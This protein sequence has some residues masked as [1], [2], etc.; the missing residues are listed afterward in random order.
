MARVPKALVFP[1]SAL[2]LLASVVLA[3]VIG[4]VDIPVLYILKALISPLPWVGPMVGAPPDWVSTVVW[5]LRLP[6][7]AMA[8]FVGVGLSVSGASMQG[9]FR[10]PLV[11]PFIL[12][13]SAGGAFGWV[14]ALTLTQGLGGLPT[15]A[16]RAFFSFVFSV[17]AVILA[18]TIA[19]SGGR[20]PLNNLLLAGIAVSASLTSL[21]QVL[22][23]L[24]SETPS[25]LIFSL[26][27]SCANSRWDEVAIVAPIVLIGA[28]ALAM[29]SRDM[30]AL[31]LG[32][33]DA[34]GLGVNVERSKAAVL[35][36]SCLV[37]AVS[38][39]FCGMIGFVG[40]M[41]PHAV[42]RIVGPDN[43]VLIPASAIIGGS[44]LVLCDLASRSALEVSIPLGIVTGMLGGG[45][46]LYLLAVQ[47]RAPA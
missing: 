21:T 8:L 4:P 33:D 25:Q 29:L 37:T 26:M 41:V 43:R 46:F 18:Y 15:L 1:G 47:R 35:G 2:L 44:F 17:A 45:F 38:I 13:I 14:V 11:D 22:I 36:L 42:R 3:V 23:Y 6:V 28:T 5:R 10:N 7:A 39:P 27:G 20:L 30:N 9:L 16:L 31:S 12:G 40:L 19:R 24:F 32:E 34:R